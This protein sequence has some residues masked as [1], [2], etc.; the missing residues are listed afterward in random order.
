MWLDDT[1]GALGSMKAGAIAMESSTITVDW[2]KELAAT[3]AASGQRFLEAPVAGSWPQEEADILI[4]IC[5][6]GGYLH[7]GH[8]RHAGHERHPESCR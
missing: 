1:T 4:Y 6:G 8:A 2:A 3:V 5:G 7:R